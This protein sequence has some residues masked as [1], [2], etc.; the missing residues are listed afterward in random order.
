MPSET[1]AK[2]TSGWI[3]TMTVSAPRSRAI[4]AIVRSVRA[5][6]E[7][8]TSSAATSMITPLDRCRPICST[9][10]SRKRTIC[11]SSSAVWI[12]AIR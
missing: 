11:V 10:S 8:R 12:E 4:S 2:A 7:S 5:P 6:K 9:R 3:P 1:I